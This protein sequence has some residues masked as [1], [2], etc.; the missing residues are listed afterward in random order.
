[1]PHG[2][3]LVGANGTGKSTLG[4]ELARVLDFSHFDVEDYYFYKTEI[5][6]TAERP[7]DERNDL[8]LADIKKHGSFVM[9]GNISGWSEIF[10]PMLDLAVLLKAPKDVRMKR[11]EAREYARWGDRIHEGGDMY[12]SH[13]KFKDFAAN[14]DDFKI[15]QQMDL[16][17][18]PVIEIDSTEN[19]RAIAKYI[20]GQITCWRPDNIMSNA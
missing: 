5:P 20:A 13:Q 12:E 9:S 6:Y 4:R 18:C 10:L 19:Y 1:M 16:F 15:E 2:I 14:R 7:Y 11:I 17:T 8:L 3:I